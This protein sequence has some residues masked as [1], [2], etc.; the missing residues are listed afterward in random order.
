MEFKFYHLIGLIGV[1]R[2]M[3]PDRMLFHTDCDTE[4][5]GSWWRE[6][7]LIP[8]LEIVH[9]PTP[10]TIFG[11]TII[12]N[13][14]RSDVL[15]LQMLLV[16]GGVYVD[17][18]IWMF[19]SPERLRYY[20]YVAN[21]AGEG[22]LS[23]GIIFATKDSAFLRMFYESFRNFNIIRKGTILRRDLHTSNGLGHPPLRHSFQSQRPDA[24]SS[25]VFNAHS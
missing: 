2:S 10:E 9:H 4:P 20:D 19:R 1:Y 25:K 17:L 6:A 3:K 22:K 21:R 13:T 14:H 12:I 16:H 7:K 23:D 5:T 8:I 24:P 11:K 15:R 18:D